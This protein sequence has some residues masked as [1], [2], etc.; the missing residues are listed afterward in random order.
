MQHKQTKINVIII[1]ASV[2]LAVVQ[3]VILNLNSTKGERLSLITEDIGIINNLNSQLQQEI[4]SASALAN[5]STKAKD[6]GFVQNKQVL[7]MGSSVP[8][9]FSR[10]SSL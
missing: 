8:I 7:S 9:A 3:V 1:I 4:A 5:I 10:S 6:F 2:I